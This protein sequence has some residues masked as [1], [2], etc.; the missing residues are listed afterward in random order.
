MGIASRHFRNKRVL[1][2]KNLDDAIRSGRYDFNLFFD[3]PGCTIADAAVVGGTYLIP[4]RCVAG[5]YTYEFVHVGPDTEVTGGF[6][7]TLRT[8]GGLNL[9]MTTDTV[10]NGI[11]FNFGGTRLGHP[12]NFIPR[13]TGGGGE[14][15]FRRWLLL[16]DNVSGVD[17]FAGFVKAGADPVVSLTEMIDIVGFHIFGDSSSAL[18]PITLLYN[19]NNGG[20]TDYTEVS[21][22]TN[23]TDG[24]L[25]E[26]EV[27]CVGSYFQYYINGV[28]VGTSTIL[29]ADL[30]D[31][32]RPILRAVETT[33][34]AADMSLL[35]TEGGPLAFRSEEL[36]SA[37]AGT[38]T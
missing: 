8:A 16:F 28:Q 37:L 34:G 26:L 31:E 19:Q 21:L 32:F 20:T 7:P 5:R 1:N 33:D 6:V 36:L 10:G 11:E 18:A 3:A 17:I 24:Q 38:I 22:S 4:V 14:N 15:W 23:L 9:L 25:I 12:R 29:Q 27:R 30:D 13:V 35:A 2:P